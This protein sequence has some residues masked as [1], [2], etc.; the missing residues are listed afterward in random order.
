M[1]QIIQLIIISS[2]CIMVFNGCG[3]NTSEY[4]NLVE[5]DHTDKQ[6]EEV[7]STSQNEREGLQNKYPEWFDSNGQVVYPKQPG[8]KAWKSAET[9]KELVELV[10]IPEDIIE[11]LSTEELLEAVENNPLFSFDIYDSVE[12]GIEQMCSNF[13]AMDY[14][15]QREDVAWAAW[16]HFV[17]NQVSEEVL[18]EDANKYRN[19]YLLEKYIV[20]HNDFYD[21]LS[22]EDRKELDDYMKKLD[23]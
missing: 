5:G 19:D 4:S 17:N 18:E 23:K 10:Q 2:L 3:K 7:K 13:T 15:L 21:E 20:E 8:S 1:R 9:H 12:L 6:S 22:E 16:K 14:L 11:D